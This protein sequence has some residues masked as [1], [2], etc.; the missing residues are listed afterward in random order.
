MNK[1]IKILF[2]FLFAIA[3]PILSQNKY[4]ELKRQAVVLMTEGRYSEAI[5]QLNKYIEAY[6]READGYYKRGLC[7]EQKP[8]Y[9]Y[10]VL[11]LRRAVRLDPKNFEIKRDLDR[12][13][14]IWHEQLYQKIDNL[15]QEITKDPNNVL[16]YLEIGKSYRWLEE[17]RKA[18]G[19]YDEYFKRDD[20]VSPDEIISYTEILVKTGS[21]IKG[22]IILKKYTIRYPDDW[23]IWSRYGYY[24]LWLGKYKI[25][26]DAF[27]TSL[28]IKPFFKEAQDGL[29]LATNKANLAQENPP[30]FE[31][32]ENKN[33]IDKFYRL[34]NEDPENDTIRFN[35]IN[36]LI[37]INRYEEAYQQ[38][39][40]LQPKYNEEDQFK[41]IWKNVTDYRDTTFNKNIERYT[42]E[43]K[44]NPSD[45]NAVMKLAES[46]ANL[47]Y[48]DNAIEVLNEYL[49]DIP[50][51]QDLDARFKYAQ[52]SAWNYEWEKAI[53][54]IDKLLTLDQNNLD[55]Q[56]LRGQIGVWTVQDLDLAERYLLNVLE[57]RPQDLGLL[58]SLSSLYSWK[59]NFREAKKYLD[60]AKQISPNSHDVEKA[61]S[62]YEIHLDSNDGQK[63]FVI[64]D[65]AIKLSEEG[66]CEEALVKYDEF[67][68][69][70]KELTRDEMLEYAAIASCAKEY[71]FAIEYYDKVL[72]D[73]YDFR[74]AL[75]RAKNY[76][77]NHD[78]TKALKELEN[79]SKLNPEDDEARLILADTYALT[80]QLDRSETIYR[81]L[82]SKK[83]NDSQQ[84]ELINQKMIFL[85]K[86][87]AKNKYFDKAEQIL[88]EM[89]REI[90][91]PDMKKDLRTCQLFLG[92]SYVIAGNYGDAKSVYKNL[93]NK[94]QDTSEVRIVKER[95]S[96]L[97]QTGL[98]SGLSSLGNFFSFLL[99]TKMGLIPFSTYYGDN[100]NFK[101]YNYGT[102]LDFGFIG[103]LSLGGSWSKTILDNPTVS[104]NLTQYKGLAEILLFKNL[105][106]SGSYGVINIYEESDR[107]IGD[108]TLRYENENDLS[109][110]LTYENNDARTILY[111]SNLMN[112]R[113]NANY[114][115]FSGFYN[116]NRIYG[117]SGFYNYFNLGDNNEGNDIQFRLGKKFISNG[118][119]GYE[120]YFSDYAF[121]SS[122]YYSP[123]NFVSHSIWGELNW[124][125]KKLKVKAVGK[126]GYVPKVDFILNEIFGEAIYNP[127]LKLTITARLGVGNNTRYDSSYKNLTASLLAYWSI[128]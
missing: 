111:S 47:F 86:Y 82:K 108:I 64:R 83:Q 60:M 50:E 125:F 36:E 104:R 67:R 24:T 39:Q 53:V 13:I 33:P 49:Q 16:N 68:S 46:Y 26:E 27:K 87:Y 9:Q 57:V 103:F 78:T 116:Y 59:D 7:Y 124:E 75:Y 15:T 110:V 2:L 114:Y 23:R 4:E 14:G 28:S 34:L 80:N 113:M 65:L 43:I 38:L 121:I 95:I 118:H 85:G 31:Q 79:I 77:L 106:L 109:I 91:N 74:V 100:Q 69:K 84:Q 35:L 117:I 81:E 94:A 5:E 63:I 89:D 25:A 119:F 127:T 73:K 128:Y 40:Y 123:Q 48:Y 20:N 62:N 71:T 29:E 96:W 70:R 55:Y 8:E 98:S 42:A 18:E 122:L 12:V 21:I 54:Q 22:E 88:E 90:T 72:S 61:Q 66:K 99:P 11:D 112:I 3:L 120:F 10:S 44:E 37:A 58:L 1:L 56:L 105:N 32:A 30:T 45:K 92:D 102:R 93:L 76:Y 6:P 51:D 19:W 101:L 52:Y 17:W 126:I 97:P 115:R 107:R 41:Q